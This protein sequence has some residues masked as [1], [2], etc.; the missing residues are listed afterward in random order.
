MTGAPPV[1]NQSLVKLGGPERDWENAV[2]IGD[3]RVREAIPGFYTGFLMALSESGLEILVPISTLVPPT[4][5]F[6]IQ[7]PIVVL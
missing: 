2:C 5:F 4:D 3:P 6:N 1:I 7:F